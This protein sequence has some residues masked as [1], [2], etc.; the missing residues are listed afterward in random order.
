MRLA[1]LL[2]LPVPAGVVVARRGV[3]FFASCDVSV[4]DGE[5]PSADFDRLCEDRPNEVCGLMVFDGWIANSDRHD[6]YIWYDYYGHKLVA[7]DH[8]RGL[9][10]TSGRTHLVSNRRRL[11][12]RLDPPCLADHIRSFDDFWKWMDRIDRLH[13]QTILG[14]AEEASAVDVDRALALECGNWLIERRKRLPQLFENE[15]HVFTRL[16]RSLHEPF[17]RSDDYF[18]EYC[19]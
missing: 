19:I 15:R 6:E 16:R 5:L 10:G 9:L 17:G 7:F 1:H 13:P 2:G 18:P 12:I 8:G 14:I 4:V 3:P 11:G